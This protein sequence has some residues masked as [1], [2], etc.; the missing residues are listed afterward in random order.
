MGAISKKSVVKTPFKLKI[1]HKAES[2]KL[3]IYPM[4]LFA[5]LSNL[6]RLSL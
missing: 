4:K 5:G 3:Q 6:V 1:K 2:F